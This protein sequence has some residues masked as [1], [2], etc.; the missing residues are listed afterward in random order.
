VYLRRLCDAGCGLGLT[1]LL[2]GEQI[3]FDATARKI[4]EQFPVARSWLMFGMGFLGG[5]PWGIQYVFR[6]YTD[7]DLTPGVYHSLAIRMMLA[8]TL[9]VV[10]YNAYE[11]L[12]GESLSGSGLVW[13]ALAFML[14]MFPAARYQLALRSGSV[15]V[16]G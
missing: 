8:G 1:I 14:G 13:P 4:P 11:A 10:M 15:P 12:A 2:F 16:P 7:D 3:G 5:Y 9:A 6:R